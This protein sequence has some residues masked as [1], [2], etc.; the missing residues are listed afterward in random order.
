MSDKAPA[1]PRSWICVPLEN[2]LSIIESGTRPKGGVDGYAEGIPSIGGEHL[3]STGN[4]KFDKIKFVPKE[5]YSNMRRGVIRQ[6]DLLMVKDG[7]TTGKISIIRPDFPFEKASVN[8]H[9]FILRFF[10]S[11][12]EPAYVFYYLYSEEGQRQIKPKGII[13]GITQSFTSEVSA[14]IAPLNEQ[15]RIVAKIEE[16][17]SDIDAG[18]DSLQK[19]QAKLKLYRHSVL[20]DAFSGK[21]TEKWRKQQKH[22]ESISEAVDRL[23]ELQNKKRGSKY[24]KFVCNKSESTD[25]P[26]WRRIPLSLVV[27]FIQYGTSDKATDDETGTPVLR[28]GN[29]VDGKLI[30]EKLKYYSKE[31]P[32]VDKYTLKVG[33]LLFNRTNSAE[34]VG[35]TAVYSK[36]MPASVFASYLIRVRLLSQEYNPFLLSYY[37]NSLAGQ[38]YIRSVVSQQVGQANVNATKLGRMPIPLMSLPEQEQLLQEIEQRISLMERLESDLAKNLPNAEKLKQSILKK[39]FEGKLVPQDP[40]DEPASVL[41]ERIKQE[42]A[43]AQAKA[44]TKKSRSGE[45]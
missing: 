21:L 26:E 11:T 24:V 32:D 16:L 2:T 15:R 17:F 30:F 35:K 12:I 19:A 39:A 23:N 20:K 3:T 10:D 38:A 40:K 31:W 27:D 7:A 28:M 14:P 6:N 1:I 37:I 33:D 41:L 42:K 13:G 44:K 8:E 18:I 36:G 9:V 34:L 29:I 43:K 25:L 22:I 4:F 45:D 5:F